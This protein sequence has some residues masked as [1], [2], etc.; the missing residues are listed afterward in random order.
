MRAIQIEGGFGID[1]LR[2]VERPD[3][4]PAADQVLVRIAA[5][6]LNYRDLLMVRGHYDPR[7][8]LPLVPCSDAAGVVVEVG[9]QVRQLRVGDRVMPIFAQDWW[10]GDPV[11]AALRSTLGGPRDG[12]LAE[13]V[14][15]PEAGLVPIPAHLDDREAATLPCAALTAWSALVTHGAIAPGASVLTLGTGGVSLFALQLAKLLGARVAITSSSEA[16]LA[17]AQEL[18][19]DHGIHYPSDP[20]WGRSARRWAGGEGVDQVIELGGAGTLPQSLEAVR[21]GGRLSLIGVLAGAGA[22][23]SLL[24]I[25]M[26][27]ITVQ[28]IFVG[29]RMGFEALNRAAAEHRL[30]PVIDRVFPFEEAGAALEHLAGGAHFGKI[31]IEIA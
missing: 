14:A 7:Q 6:S 20:T 9:D 19:A 18:G 3:P 10:D 31:V 29:H 17:R 24:P 13:L 28:G 5:V 16:K 23:L 2:V 4:R 8:P 1:H 26:R 30:R 15:L 25:L 21:P 11:R 12:V 22:K 27:N